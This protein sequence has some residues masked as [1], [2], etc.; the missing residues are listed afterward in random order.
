MNDRKQ[1]KLEA[2]FPRLPE[3]KLETMNWAYKMCEFIL[4]VC[5]EQLHEEFGFGNIEDVAV[6]EIIIMLGRR[7]LKETE[8]TCTEHKKGE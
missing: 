1:K 3:E 7:Y 4:Q 5:K 8:F 6:W 2:L